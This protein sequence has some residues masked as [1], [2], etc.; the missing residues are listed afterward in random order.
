MDRV[1]SSKNC[2][3]LQLK[4]EAGA[5]EAR[6]MGLCFHGWGEAVLVLSR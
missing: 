2:L 1:Q 5:G 3:G 4:T 6:G